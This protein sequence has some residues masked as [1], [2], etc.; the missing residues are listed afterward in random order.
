MIC[1][2]WYIDRHGM[3]ATHSCTWIILTYTC[4]WYACARMCHTHVH[5]WMH[6][7]AVH[8]YCRGPLS[9]YIDGFAH[10]FVQS[11]S[12]KLYKRACHNT[13]LGCTQLGCLPS[14]A[15]VVASSVHQCIDT[16]TVAST[17]VLTIH[18]PRP[19]IY[20][21]MCRIYTYPY[22]Y[23]LSCSWVVSEF[24]QNSE[25]HKCRNSL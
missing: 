2:V 10:K 3:N 15:L 13:S 17:F 11:M 16:I 14:A 24:L 18:H 25:T 4:L 21:D 19:Q 5:G 23:I 6:K 8:V 1:V 7:R 9:E 22:N 20:R 12:S